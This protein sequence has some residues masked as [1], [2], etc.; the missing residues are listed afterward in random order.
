MRALNHFGWHR[1]QI[2]LFGLDSFD[3]YPNYHCLSNYYCCFCCYHSYCYWLCFWISYQIGS[4]VPILISLECIL[5]ELVMLVPGLWPIWNPTQ[6]QTNDAAVV[7]VFLV[8]LVSCQ[9]DLLIGS[10]VHHPLGEWTGMGSG[11]KYPWYY[12]CFRFFCVT[13]RT[14]QNNWQNIVWRV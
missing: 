1:S 7:V 12:L 4:I 3:I 9:I 11:P 2:G 10:F 8:S 5:A 6:E 13:I 14:T